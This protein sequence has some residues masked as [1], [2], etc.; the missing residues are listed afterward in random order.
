LLHGYSAASGWLKLQAICIG[1]LG[2]A[3]IPNETYSITGLKLKLRSP[4]PDMFNVELANGAEGYIPPPEALPLGG[5]NA[6]PARTAGLQ[7]DADT[8][9][10]DTLLSMFEE[11]SGKQREKVDLSQAPFQGGQS[12]FRCAKTGTAPGLFL[13]SVREPVT[14]SP[15]PRRRGEGSRFLDRLL[16][17]GR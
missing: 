7:P 16:S 10:A 15:S 3:A 6:W 8:I 14:P 1:D 2:I 13:E 12:H 5:Y 11:L 4:M 9:I 17:P